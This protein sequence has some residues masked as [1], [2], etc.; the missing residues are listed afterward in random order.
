MAYASF[1]AWLGLYGS[2]AELAG[3]FLVNFA[4]WGANCGRMGQALKAHYGFKEAA[5]TFFNLFV[6]SQFEEEAL[7]VIQRGLDR[8]VEPPLIQR[9]A[10][11]L[12]GYE[13]MFWDTMYQVSKS[14]DV[15]GG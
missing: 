3:A 9:A 1:V 7:A 15:S 8:D 6:E 11:L 10:R 4:A 13:L 14:H 12:Q 5:L 2:D